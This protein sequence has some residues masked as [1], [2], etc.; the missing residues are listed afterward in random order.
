MF[1]ENLAKAFTGSYYNQFNTNKANLRSFYRPESML[2]FTGNPCQ[3]PDAIIAQF[4]SLPPCTANVLSV[5]AQENKVTKGAIIV[6]NGDLQLT[7]GGK[8]KFVET[9]FLNPVDGAA[10]QFFILNHI[11]RIQNV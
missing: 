2:T 6:V 7:S 3:G 1:A 10:G 4:S 11:F 5:A 9:F 8:T